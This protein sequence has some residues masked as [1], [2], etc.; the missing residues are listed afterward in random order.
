MDRNAESGVLAASG[1]RPL[2]A[3]TSLRFPGSAAVFAFH[4]TAFMAGSEG[5]T[6]LGSASAVSLFFVLS[7]FVLAYSWHERISEVGWAGFV[8]RRIARL[9]PVHLACL[10][11]VLAVRVGYF[12]QLEWRWM[13]LLANV[14]L[15]QSWIPDSA[16]VFSFNGVSWFVAT[17]FGFCLFFP[18]ML[19]MA[20]RFPARS[21][22]VIAGLH[23]TLLWCA[24][25]VLRMDP[26][27]TGPVRLVIQANPLFRLLE[28][29]TGICTGWLFVQGWRMPDSRAG[30]AAHTLV[31]LLAIGLLWQTLRIGPVGQRMFEWA[32]SLDWQAMKV[33]LSK[34]GS[35]LPASALLIWVLA[36]SRG[37]VARMLEHPLPVF[38]GRI[39]FAFFMIH[40]IV[41]SQTVRYCDRDASPV[42]L[43]GAAFLVSI[44]LAALL[45]LLVELPGRQLLMTL[46]RADRSSKPVAPPVRQPLGR[47]A[48]NVVIACA[49]MAAG[50]VALV[51]DDREWL[52]RPRP[53]NGIEEVEFHQ[54][55][56][57]EGEAAL[58]HVSAERHDGGLDLVL[59]WKG[60]PGQT[61][62]RFLH[63]CDGEEKI[64]RQLQRKEGLFSGGDFA[65]DRIRIPAEKL[66]DVAFVG[67]GFWSRSLGSVPVN[68]TPASMNGKRLHVYDCLADRIP[69]L[70][71]AAPAHQ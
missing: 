39:S 8:W 43:T 55:I 46:F 24:D 67:V 30:T 60:L 21:L 14:L 9:W 10:A 22:L 62:D 12:E 49:A 53:A 41:L 36:S 52:V 47:L 61:R 64:L 42:A 26:Q 5:A 70:V 54:A 4:A 65:V 29:Y 7:G 23:L 38:L 56:I 66:Q 20:R 44:G 2:P 31:E 51:A 11:L 27:L 16:T 63:L 58:L 33:W 69:E 59:I 28:F 40:N 1:Y 34:G 6:W 48:G 35:S 3:L 32:E 71:V 50:F 45:H 68:A 57:F 37:L 13:R 15:V 17:E 19:G 18:L 25:L